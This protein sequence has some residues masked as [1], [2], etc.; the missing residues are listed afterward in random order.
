MALVARLLE[1]G[2]TELAVVVA[3]GGAESGFG[4]G[5]HFLVMAVAVSASGLLGERGGGGH[6]TEDEQ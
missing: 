4:L 1:L 5:A 2:Q 6:G 3:V